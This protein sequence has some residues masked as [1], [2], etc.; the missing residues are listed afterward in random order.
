MTLMLK[1][2][3]RLYNK[4][5]DQAALD[6]LNCQILT[7]VTQEIKNCNI[8]KCNISITSDITC[9]LNFHIQELE[10]EINFLRSELQKKNCLGKI[11]G[12]FTYVP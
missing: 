1:K 10:S 5:Y 2:Y 6:H 12:N 4:Q 8:S 7:K 11:S 9:S 3:R